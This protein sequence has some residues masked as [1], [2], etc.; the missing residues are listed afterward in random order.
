LKA[1]STAQTGENP[2]RGIG[3]ETRR[4]RAIPIKKRIFSKNRHFCVSLRVPSRLNVPKNGRRRAVSVLLW[5]RKT[6]L[7]QQAGWFPNKSSKMLRGA[8]FSA[9][10]V[11][12]PPVSEQLYYFFVFFAYR[13][14]KNLT[15]YFYSVIV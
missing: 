7:V 14:R 3:P 11:R 2:Q 5:D 6:G 13:K 9:E 1:A 8:R 4:F 10:V 12:K 15:K